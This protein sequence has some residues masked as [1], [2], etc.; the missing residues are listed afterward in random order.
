MKH[1]IVLIFCITSLF[2]CKKKLESEGVVIQESSYEQNIAEE[3]VKEFPICDKNKE[4]DYS[5]K[6]LF[7]T[8]EIVQEDELG[9]KFY[10]G[11]RK[12]DLRNL[13]NI[14]FLDC[15]S[16]FKES[17]FN[18]FEFNYLDLKSAESVYGTVK[19]LHKVEGYI[20]YHDFFKRG[21]VFILTEKKVIMLTYNPFVKNYLPQKVENYFLDNAENYKKV[22]VSTGI[23]SIKE[24]ISKSDN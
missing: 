18:I 17:S 11:S 24:I 4:A 6:D 12:K 23:N 10:Y 20:K 14:E 2:S 21:L 9:A 1:I 22:I 5:F 7:E 15:I 3:P 13:F 8:Q 19:D 16:F